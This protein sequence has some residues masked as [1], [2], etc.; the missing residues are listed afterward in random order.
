MSVILILATAG[1]VDP[2]ASYTILVSLYSYTID[3]FCGLLLGLGLLLLRFSGARKWALK[4]KTNSSV[5]ITAALLY[6]I[7][8]IFPIILV[9]VP[10]SS[11]VN[12]LE[13]RNDNTTPNGLE[14]NI[15]P[16]SKISWFVT[17]TVGWS[18][19]AFGVAYWFGFYYL[20][21]R[22]GDH[23]GKELKVHRKLY[24]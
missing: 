2:T 18:L 8:N 15:P 5:S 4:S 6:T 19:I 10:P 22:I 16:A 14:L 12:Q 23:K 24:F 20:V 21:P 17:P 9:W 1:Q 7:V 11:T 3:V 13:H